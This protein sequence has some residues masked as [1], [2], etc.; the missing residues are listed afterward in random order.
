MQETTKNRRCQNKTGRCQIV[1]LHRF[2]FFRFP[3]TLWISFFWDVAILKLV[4][5]DD[6]SK[7]VLTDFQIQDYF[8]VIAFHR[9]LD[10]IANFYTAHGPGNITTVLDLS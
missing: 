4:R 7:L 10:D 3:G 5:T 1:N 8:A 2:V 9:H 6:R